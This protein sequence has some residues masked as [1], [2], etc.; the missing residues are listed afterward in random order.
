MKCAWWFLFENCDVA[1]AWDIDLEAMAFNI[2]E[3]IT[4]EEIKAAFGDRVS[5]LNDE[6]LFLE[7]F[8]EFQ[9]G[10]LS[11]ECKPHRP[12]LKRL[13]SI[14]L[15]KGYRKGFKTLEEKEKE[16]E[17]EK[18][19]EKEEEEG[20]CEGKQKFDFESLYRKYPKKVGK[21]DGFARL[22]VQIKTQADYDAFSLA[23][24]RYVADC[25]KTERILKDFSTFVSPNDKQ[26]WR[27]WLDDETT[28]DVPLGQTEADWQKE[29]SE[30]MAAYR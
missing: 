28:S 5:V 12:V 3:T 15:L 11:H 13:E 17:Q 20:E 22:K 18:D 19:K 10:T 27:E 9:Y 8:V 4:L 30:K 2:G 21:T 23:I 1:G 24:D 29:M 25:K 6:K 7:T 14:T 26:S 16:K